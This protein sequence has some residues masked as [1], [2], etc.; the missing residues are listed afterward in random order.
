M[1]KRLAKFLSSVALVALLASCGGNGGEGGGGGGGGG[2]GLKKVEIQFWHTFGQ[3]IQDNLGPQIEQFKKLVKANENVEIEVNLKP[4]SNYDSIK[5]QIDKNLIIGKGPTLAVGYPD[6]VA[7][8]MYSEMTPGQFVVN[9]DDYITNST[10]GLGKDAYLGD[11]E[12]DSLDD[13][14]DAYIDGGK[15]FIREGTYTFPYMKSTEAM[16]YNFDAVE[17]VLT[18]YKPD[19]AGNETKIKE[20]MDNLDWEEFMNLCRETW[21]YRAEISSAMEYPAFYDSD[22]NLF[23]SQLHQAG[24]PYSSINKSTMTGQIDFAEGEARTDAE[25][26]VTDL[27]GW[28]Q[29]HLFTTKGLYSTYGSDSFKNFKTVFTIGST[30][31]SGY[32]LTTDFRIGVCKVPSIDKDNSVYVV[33]GPDLCIFNNPTLSEQA[34]KDRVLYAWKLI[35]FLTNPKNNCAI[36]IN[37]SEGYL[38]VRESAYLEDLYLEF[39]ESGEPQAQIAK[40]VTDEINGSYFNTACFMG[41]ATLRTQVGAIVTLSCDPKTT[42]SVSSV[43][44]TAINNAI[45]DIK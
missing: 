29:E 19:I 22:S 23:I 44:Q 15:H 16:L 30:G 4:H 24:I 3:T 14:I 36:A 18:H 8:Y 10:Y 7:G 13:F 38:P 37:G 39:I 12:N 9:L 40:V 32:S 34:N 27:K 11:P 42:D 26:I 21:K 41:S 45:L 31:G 28:H 2:E 25:E 20:Y 1:N 6:H 33:Q 35:K 43:F 17:K 5:E